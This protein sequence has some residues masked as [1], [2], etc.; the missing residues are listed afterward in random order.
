MGP[1][2]CPSVV[3]KIIVPSNDSIKIGNDEII[4]TTNNASGDFCFLP[5]IVLKVARRQYNDYNSKYGML[6]FSSYHQFNPLVSSKGSFFL[7]SGSLLRFIHSRSRTI[8]IKELSC[9]FNYF[10]KTNE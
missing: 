5:L 6:S 3:S 1:P 2:C 10:T 8:I 7:Y 4:T 9:K